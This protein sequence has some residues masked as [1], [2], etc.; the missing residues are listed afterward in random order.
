MF[1]RAQHVYV[2]GSVGRDSFILNLENQVFLSGLLHTPTVLSLGTAHG[3]RYAGVWVI[4]WIDL[5]AMEKKKIYFSAKNKILV[6][7][8]GLDALEKRKICSKLIGF[9]GFFHLCIKI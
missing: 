1:T 9:T 8:A 4:S 5:N 6:P 3:V 2:L 7:R